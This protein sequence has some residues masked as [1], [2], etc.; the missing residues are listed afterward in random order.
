MILSYY[1]LTEI[2]FEL[3][4][5]ASDLQTRDRF[6]KFCLPPAMMEALSSVFS[7]C[8]R[9]NVTC[10]SPLCPMLPVKAGG[11]EII[12]CRMFSPCTSGHLLPVLRRLNAS[13]TSLLST[14]SAS[15]L[16]FILHKM[17]TSCRI[18]VCIAQRLTIWWMRK[19]LL[20][21]DQCNS[22]DLTCSTGFI[23]SFIHMWESRLIGPHTTLNFS[24][25]IIKKIK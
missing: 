14:C 8:Q 25:K 5:W 13:R 12:V 11:G 4:S 1:Y 22:S 3:D 24:E 20:I 19:A 15:W 6:G 16:L 9:F 18:M 2:Q 7:P 23:H 17:A 10:S 21:T